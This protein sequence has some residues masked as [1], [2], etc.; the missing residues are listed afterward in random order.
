M[1]WS[2]TSFDGG[3]RDDVEILVVLGPF[4]LDA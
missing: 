1:V 2:K 4:L 3:C